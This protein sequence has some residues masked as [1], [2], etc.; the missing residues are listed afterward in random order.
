M[1]RLISLIG[2]F[3][4]VIIQTSLLPHFSARGF[5]PSIILVVVFCWSLLGDYQEAVFWAIGGGA[6][7][8]IFSSANFSVFMISLLLVVLMLY[9]ISNTVV[10]F[11]KYYMRAWLCGLTSLIYCLLVVL[12]P[13]LLY[14]IFSPQAK[15]DLSAHVF[16]TMLISVIVNIAAMLIIFPLLA[17]YQKVINGF[18]A[19]VKNRL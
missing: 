17:K 8:D 19:S 6:L 12:L 18:M 14:I 5:L 10:S 13:W 4:V 2:I 16:L 11:D 3:L 15:I 7:L 9:L 1:K